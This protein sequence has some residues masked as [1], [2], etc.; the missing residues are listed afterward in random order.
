MLDTQTLDDFVA[1][2]S[3]ALPKFKK[4]LEKLDKPMNFADW[5]DLFRAWLE[6]GTEMETIYHG[7]RNQPKHDD[8][9][10]IPTLDTGVE[11]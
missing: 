7:H 4:N 9:E 3:D 2:V 10:P 6:V 1:E 8:V 11:K 5:Y